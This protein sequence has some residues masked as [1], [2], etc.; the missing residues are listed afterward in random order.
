MLT[1]ADILQGRILIVDDRPVDV[2][3]LERMLRNAGYLS[4]SSTTD[5]GQVRALHV[6]N[7][8]DLILLDLQMPGM[9]GFEVMEELKELEK[10]GYLAVLA[11]TANPAHKVRALQAGAKDFV[12][13]PFDQAEVLLRVHNMLEVRLL[14]DA[15][16]SHGKVLESLALN[17]PLTGLANRRLL[18]DRMSMAIVHARRNK[19][20][21]SVVYVDLDRFKQINDSLGHGVGDAVLQMTAA[22]LVA[23][24]REEDTVARLGGDE[25]MISLWHVSGADH[26]TLVASRV[27]EALSHPF[28]VEGRPVSVTASAGVAVYPI[29]GVD[30]ETLMKSADVALY[31]AK[32]AGKNAYRLAGLTEPPGQPS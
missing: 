26:A 17:D 4:V 3:L 23:L 32:H 9:N 24:V 8:Y 21:M 5:P 15:A 18:A 14:H 22:R 25:F 28:D 1:S 6:E 7:R 20:A 2:Q 29:H 10:E 12:S 16:R 31:Q 30:P 13:K 11:V 19:S 27:I